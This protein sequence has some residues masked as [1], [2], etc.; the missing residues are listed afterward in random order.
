MKNEIFKVSLMNFIQKM[1]KIKQ[2]ITTPRGNA[3]RIQSCKMVGG[4]KKRIGH[5]REELFNNQFG[6]KGSALTYKA[7]ADCILAKDNNIYKQLIPALN[8]TSDQKNVSIKSGNNLQFTLGNI[9]EI[10]NAE[11]KLDVMKDVKLWNK[12]LKKSESECPADL[13]AYFTES[14]WIFFKMDNVVEFITNRFTWRQLPSGRIK[15]DCDGLQYLTYE[16]RSGHRSHFLGAN[17]NKGKPFIEKLKSSIP[18]V[19]TSVDK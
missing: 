15:G 18:Y 14:E 11:N 1:S 12:Y 6:V 8:I 10:T 5:N 4:F 7:Q 3:K 16:Y 19:S 2:T 9:P 13:L 17:G